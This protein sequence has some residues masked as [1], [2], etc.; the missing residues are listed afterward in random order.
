MSSAKTREPAPENMPLMNT[1][2][3]VFFEEIFLVQLFSNPQ[4][5]VAA[6]T[7]SEP[8]ENERL[9]QLQESRIVDMVIK[10]MPAQSLAVTFFAEDESAMDRCG[11]DLKVVEERGLPRRSLCVTRTLRRQSRDCRGAPLRL[12]KQVVFL[13]DRQIL[14]TADTE[15]RSAPMPTPAPS[16][17]TPPSSSA[18]HSA[19]AFFG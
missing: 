4:Q 6:M 7:R 5:T 1:I 15:H 3:N 10:A 8:Q 2:S 17:G 9:D 14:R 12:R 11:R 19:A 13:T 18:A 16:R